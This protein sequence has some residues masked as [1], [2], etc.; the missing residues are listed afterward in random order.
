VVVKYVGCNLT[1]LDSCSDDSVKGALGAYKPVEW[2]SGSLEKIDIA[3][4][5]ELYAK[6]PLGAAELSGRVHGGE[7][8]HMEYFVSG[9]RPASRPA[10]Y[11]KELEKIPGCRG[12][13]HF[14]YAYNL[15]AF[16]LGSLKQLGGE[17]N[18]SSMF[19]F[20]AQANAKAN[21]TTNAE[22]K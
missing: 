12:A 4:E 7:K 11:K 10:V 15:G 22:K 1:V 13:T 21:K 9:T 17:V 20:G 14:V 2:T 16:A 3:N 5:G 19:G 18:G 6:L 8:F